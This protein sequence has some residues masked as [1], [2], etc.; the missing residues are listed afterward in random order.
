MTVV[1][2]LGGG[3]TDSDKFR[4]VVVVVVVVV[5]SGDVV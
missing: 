4:C 3:C 1:E 5:V 2:E